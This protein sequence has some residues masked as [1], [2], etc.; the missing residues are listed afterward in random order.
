MALLSSHFFLMCV[1]AAVVAA[2]VAVIDP[3]RHTLRDRALYGARV[4]GAFVGIGVV[5]GWLMRFIP[6]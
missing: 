6:F 3:D 5:L 1:F 2:V 4:F